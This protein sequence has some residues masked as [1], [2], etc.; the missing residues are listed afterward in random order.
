[1]GGLSS[2]F[3]E[4]LHPLMGVLRRRL[5]QPHQPSW[6]INT[7]SSFHSPTFKHPETRALL[8]SPIQVASDMA[9]VIC[10]KESGSPPTLLSLIMFIATALFYHIHSS[11]FPL[12]ATQLWAGKMY[13]QSSYWREPSPIITS[14]ELTRR[15]IV[16][17]IVL[18][19][20]SISIDS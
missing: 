8:S 17:E 20:I 3:T 16:P 7:R 15:R 18:I 1:M 14:R 2:A 6:V 4:F 9:T 5:P 12:L 11:L 13:Q 19:K 10:I